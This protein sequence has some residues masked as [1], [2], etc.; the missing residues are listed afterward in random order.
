[1]T[2]NSLSTSSVLLGIETSQLPSSLIL[3]LSDARLVVTTEKTDAPPRSQHLIVMIRDLLADHHL[4]TQ[5]LHAIA[6]SHGP[7][8]FTGLRIGIT[9]AKTLAYALNIPLFAV[10]T[11]P[12]IAFHTLTILSSSITNPPAGKMIVIADAFRGKLFVQR[13]LTSQ[14]Q[15][16][17]QSPFP[18]PLYDVHMESPGQLLDSLSE[19]DLLTGPGLSK[20]THQVPQHQQIP[21]NPL[22]PL[23][24]SLIAYWEQPSST[25]LPISPFSLTP[26]YVRAS[27][28]EEKRQESSCSSEPM[29][30]EVSPY[31]TQADP[32]PPNPHSRNHP[33]SI[34]QTSPQNT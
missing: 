8:S 24:S 22:P 6:V 5:N 19:N 11:F 14:T 23:A 7:G 13:F 10:P 16:P 34:D 18:T 25:M 31:N 29:S 21:L 12:L 3:R 17:S 27:A 32:H 30:L 4:S 33:P 20:I 1:M 15:F 28:A 2:S 9:T 26:L